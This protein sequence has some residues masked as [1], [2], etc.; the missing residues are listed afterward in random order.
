[1]VGLSWEGRPFHGYGGCGG[2]Q[3]ETM[4]GELRDMGRGELKERKEV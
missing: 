1:M 4:E 2:R 3:G